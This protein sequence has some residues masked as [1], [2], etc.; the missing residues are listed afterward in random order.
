MLKILKRLAQ[1][2]VRESTHSEN[3]E[4]MIAMMKILVDNY[5]NLVFVMCMIAL[6]RAH[7]CIVYFKEHE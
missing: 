6:K 7:F 5:D 3:R 1:A 2:T 4:T